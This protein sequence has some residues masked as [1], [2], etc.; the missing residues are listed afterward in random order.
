MG[1]ETH[2]P[3][4]TPAE[5]LAELD[6]S[7]K[8]RADGIKFFLVKKGDLYPEAEL[9]FETNGSKRISTVRISDRGVIGIY[10]ITPT[11]ILLSKQETLNDGDHV[12]VSAVEEKII[13]EHIHTLTEYF[14]AHPDDR[15]K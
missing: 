10:Q 11:G 5:I 15:P 13:N 3:R 7:K 2:R 6:A 4:M 14:N 12:N 9:S 1:Y 8:R